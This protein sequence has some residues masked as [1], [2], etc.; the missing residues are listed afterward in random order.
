V[1]GNCKNP[2]GGPAGPVSSTCSSVGSCMNLG[3]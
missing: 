1:L 3:S 2:S